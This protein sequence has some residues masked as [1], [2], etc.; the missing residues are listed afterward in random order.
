MRKLTLSGLV[1]FESHVAGNSPGEEDDCE[2][3]QEPALVLHARQTE[4]LP[5]ELHPVDVGSQEA[6]GE[7]KEK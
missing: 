7:D 4:G 6:A 5:E 2:A 1:D 3:E